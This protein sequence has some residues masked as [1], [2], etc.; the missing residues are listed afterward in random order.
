MTFFWVM[1]LLPSLGDEQERRR[2]FHQVWMQLRPI[3]GHWDPKRKL[4]SLVEV[5]N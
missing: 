2:F 1:N 3:S 4:F 5:C